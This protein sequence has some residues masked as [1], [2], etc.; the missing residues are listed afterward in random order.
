[1]THGSVAKQKPASPDAPAEPPGPHGPRLVL[2]SEALRDDVAPYEPA[3]RRARWA[4]GGAG[5]GLALLGLSMRAGQGQQGL[6]GASTTFAAAAAALALAVL[7]FSYLVRGGAAWALG[8][9][10]FLVGAEGAGPLGHGPIDPATDLARLLAVA[11]LPGALLF[12]ARYRTYRRA[13]IVLAAALTGAVPFVLVRSLSAV[14]SGPSPVEKAG[15]ALAVFTVLCGL[16][17]FM[18]EDT[19]AGGSVWA[20][21]L[22]AVLGTDLGLRG[23][24]LIADVGTGPAVLSALWASVGATCA[25]ALV[26]TGAFKLLAG[27]LA[28]DARRKAKRGQARVVAT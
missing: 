4:I 2:A 22:I 17:G 1:M 21:L 16:T 10:L 14:H 15:A 24:R 6:Y 27:W 26:A 28:A 5:F 13:R 8:M 20:A 7:P 3:R 9:L 18:G 25:G 12:R 11:A 19:T 23:F